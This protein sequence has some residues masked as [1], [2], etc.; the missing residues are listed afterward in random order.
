MLIDVRRE[1]VDAAIDGNP[2]I[3]GRGVSGEVSRGDG[4]GRL[5]PFRAGRCSGGPFGLIVVGALVVPS[6]EPSPT[7]AVVTRPDQTDLA[8]ESPTLY[9]QNKLPRAISTP[10]AATAM[11]SPRRGAGPSAG[12]LRS[13]SHS[14]ITA[15]SIT[16][17]KIGIR[18][19]SSAWSNPGSPTLPSSTSPDSL[20]A[21]LDPVASSPDTA[22]TQPYLPEN[23]GQIA[24]ASNPRAVRGTST[25]AACTTKGW[26]GIPSIRSNGPPEPSVEHPSLQRVTIDG[27]STDPARGVSPRPMGTVQHNGRELERESVSGP[28]QVAGPSP[29]RIRW[30]PDGR[31][32]AR[33][34]SSKEVPCRHPSRGP[35]ESDAAHQYLVDRGHIDPIVAVSTPAGRLHA[36]DADARCEIGSVTKVFTSLL[37]AELART[38][39]VRLDDAVGRPRPRREPASPVVLPRSRSSTWPATGPDCPGCHRAY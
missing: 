20:A 32:A 29:W 33:G 18:S 31:G 12:A 1:V 37:L 10:T 34:L 15:I 36:G 3:G 35:N 21:K 16:P 7:P 4:R 38:G 22:T 5:R 24:I 28:R 25:T 11:R 39:D 6:P 19:P 30:H 27:T 26:T 14:A 8:P 23:R 2:A 17:A 13:M 9:T